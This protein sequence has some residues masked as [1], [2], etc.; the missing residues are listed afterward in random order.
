MVMT[1]MGWGGDTYN[2][3]SSDIS[4]ET[5]KKHR[6]T[7]LQTIR[8]KQLRLKMLTTTVA[9][10]IKLS[11]LASTPAGAVLALPVAYQYLRAM[12]E[13]VSEQI[14]WSHHG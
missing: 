1:R 2:L 13:N 12:S 4:P 10:A 9:V 11:A 5:L 6:H 8:L 14:Q 7:V 3:L